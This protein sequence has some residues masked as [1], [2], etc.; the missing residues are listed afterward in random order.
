MGF[1]RLVSCLCAA[2]IAFTAI[3][4]TADAAAVPASKK[5][6]NLVFDPPKP[7]K[8]SPDSLPEIEL[9]GGLLFQL[10][11]SEIAL[12]RNEL[13][14]AYSTYMNVA[15]ETGDPR[16]AE[17]AVQIAQV[18]KAPRE[19]MRSVLLWNKLAPGNRHAQEMLIRIGL[20]YQEY[21]KILLTTQSFLSQVEDPGKVILGLQSQ[22]LIGKDRKK[23]LTFFRKATE[24]FKRLPET[25]LGLARLEGLVGN[26]KAAERF[27]KESYKQKPNPE[28]VMTLVSVLLQKKSNAGQKEARQ[29]LG[30]YLAK[31]PKDLRIRDSY[32][33]LLLLS[34]DYNQLI[35]LVKKYP[36]DYEFELSTAVSL[37][38]NNHETEAEDLLNKLA[39][40]PQDDAESGTIP[41]KALL[42]LSE[43]ALENKKYEEALALAD[44]VVGS[45]KPAALIQKANVYSHEDKHKEALEVL[46]QVDPGDNN[47]VAE[48]VAAVES[49]LIAE[50]NG[51]TEALKTLEKYLQKYPESKS[52]FYEAAMIAERLDLI[53]MAENYLKRALEI[54]PN[55]ANAYNS[56]GY[57]LLE[58]TNRLKGRRKH[59]QGV[60]A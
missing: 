57:T 12:Q 7:K 51:D 39:K 37:L 33:Q 38:Q 54:D 36:N 34:S 29:V 27:A 11:A 24:K 58:R 9:T 46:K 52:L 17:R 26:Q 42:L 40:L 55:F 13:G 3:P 47:A 32:A 48:E 4:M 59:S 56:L 18:A 20:H 22:L 16:L 5:E 28:S 21:N 25:K 41:Q 2:A 1:N 50:L 30:Q 60:P 45:M 53:S 8:F 31:N 23:A 35:E 14:A 10:I 49:R 43:V 19:I 15:E 6:L 44:R